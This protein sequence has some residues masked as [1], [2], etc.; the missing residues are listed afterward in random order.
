VSWSYT[1]FSFKFVHYNVCTFF[2][3]MQFYVDTLKGLLYCVVFYCCAEFISLLMLWCMSL[4]INVSFTD[5]FAP[6]H[7]PVY[8][9]T[10][11]WVN[12]CVHVWVCNEEVRERI[13]VHL[14]ILYISIPSWALLLSREC[15]T[16][17]SGCLRLSWEKI[18]NT[19]E[20]T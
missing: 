11:A 20:G 2:N 4:T 12:A 7:W 8:V 1:E 14:F 10:H 6:M 15:A 9:C 3:I 5:N 17:L 18:W 19:D 13:I 16:Y